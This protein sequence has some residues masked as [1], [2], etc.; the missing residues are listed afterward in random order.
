M[1]CVSP[2][3]LRRIESQFDQVTAYLLEN[4]V[5]KGVFSLVE[6]VA[7]KIRVRYDRN[8]QSGNEQRKFNTQRDAAVRKIRSDSKMCAAVTAWNTIYADNATWTYSG[9]NIVKNGMNIVRGLAS[10][11]PHLGTLSAEC[12][13]NITHHRVRVSDLQTA[14][15]HG[16]LSDVA[17]N[18]AIKYADSSLSVTTFNLARRLRVLWDQSYLINSYWGYIEMFSQFLHKVQEPDMNIKFEY[19]HIL[20]SVNK[21]YIL[22]SLLEKMAKYDGAPPNQNKFSRLSYNASLLQIIDSHEY[23]PFDKNENHNNIRCAAFILAA[24]PGGSALMTLVVTSFMAKEKIPLLP[25]AMTWRA[26][27]EFPEIFED[28]Y[29]ELGEEFL[30]TAM[31]HYMRISG[32]VATLSTYGHLAGACVSGLFYD[33][34]TQISLQKA[35]EEAGWAIATSYIAKLAPGIISHLMWVASL[36]K[37]CTKIRRASLNIAVVAECLQSDI[38][39]CEKEKDIAEHMLFM[40]QRS[41]KACDKD[42]K[43]RAQNNVIFLKL[44]L[45]SKI[46]KVA[47]TRTAYMILRR[48]YECIRLFL[49]DIH[50]WMRQLMQFDDRRQ[51]QEMGSL[52]NVLHKISQSFSYYIRAEYQLVSVAFSVVFCKLPMSHMDAAIDSLGSVEACAAHFVN[53]IAE[54]GTELVAHASCYFIQNS[55]NCILSCTDT[56]LSSEVL[57]IIRGATIGV[58]VGYFYLLPTLQMISPVYICVA[59]HLESLYVPPMIKRHWETRNKPSDQSMCMLEIKERSLYVEF[60]CIY[61]IQ[62]GEL[63]PEI[64]NELIPKNDVEE[65][66][67]NQFYKINGNLEEVI[68]GETNNENFYKL[69]NGLLLTKLEDT[70]V[71]NSRVP[72]VR[73]EW[74]ANYKNI[75]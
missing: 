66:I 40:A 32:V 14:G 6:Q 23:G 5:S 30:W 3:L 58:Y 62:S 1:V 68:Y 21:S 54:L 8:I 2:N 60:G 38:E 75:Q 45:E 13:E 31:W 50:E 35:G 19:D 59:E 52:L 47:E 53:I 61:L 29:N 64:I 57:Q 26:E 9:M 17:I 34:M 10:G 16:G 72:L 7:Q 56:I 18:Q 37:L 4:Y 20:E 73:P 41:C 39:L 43:A 46:T 55:P 42:D 28:A 69:K 70:S 65:V 11:T 25:G 44:L 74:I 48:A 71:E 24:H 36:H 63:P 15:L 49:R 27:R 22:R 12:R 33:A 67:L 51:I